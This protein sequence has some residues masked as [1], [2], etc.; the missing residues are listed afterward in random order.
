MYCAL[1]KKVNISKNE[2]LIKISTNKET[3]Y[4]AIGGTNGFVQV[5]DLDVS[6]DQKNAKGG[7]L[8][9]SQSLKYHNDDISLITWN[10]NY[11]K[12]TTCDKSGVIIVWKNVDNKWETEM[13]NNR[14]QSYVT[15][16]K[17]NRQ[18]QYLCFIYED[19]HAIVGTV[20]GNRSWG[21]DI[22]NSLYLIEWSPDGNLILLASRNQNI[23]ILSSSGQQLGEV[24]IEEELKNIDIAS[25]VWWSKYIDENKII[26]LKKHLM[27]AFINGDICL[28]DDENDIS[29]VKIKTN[30]KKITKADWNI[31]GDCFA[32]CGFLNEGDSKGCVCFYNSNGE[33]IKNIKIN[34]PIICFSFNAKGTQIAL[35]TQNTIYFG[36]IK[37]DYKWCYFGETLVYAFLSD[38]EHHTVS[39]WNTKNNSFNYKYVKN[40]LGIVSCSPFCLITAKI[41]KKGNYLL[42]LSNSIGS[43]VDNKIINIEPNLIGINS[44]HVVVSDGHYIYLWQFRGTEETANHKDKNDDKT[45]IINGEE[46]SINLLTHKMMKELCFFVEDKPNVKDIYNCNNFKC[47]RKTNDPICCLS[48]TDNY[49]FIVCKSGRGLKYDLLSLSNSEK[50]NLDNRLIKIGMSPTGRFLWTINELNYLNIWDIAKNKKLE[51]EKK[52]IWSLVWSGNNNLDLNNSEEKLN[53]AY[54]EKNKINIIKD[55]KP[56]EILDSNGYLAEFND[57]N[58]I[59][60]KLDDLLYKPNEEKKEVDDIVIKIETRALRDLRSMLTNNSPIDEIYKYVDENSSHKL[61]EIF[62]KHC[63]QNL[64][65]INAEKAMLKINDYMGLEFIKRIKSID[66]D[67]LKKAE[68]YQFYEDFDQAENEYGNNDR[69][70]LAIGMRFKLGQW[71]KVIELTTDSGVVQEDNMKM[72]YDNYAQQFLEE[73]NYEKAEEYFKKAGDV[74]G[75]INVWFK[76]E[77]YDKAIIYIERLPEGNELLLFL[78]NKFEKYGLCD[79]AVKCY[80]RYGD[81][82]KAIDTCVLMN[83]WN[84]AVEL[85]ENNNFFQIEGLVN[86][87]GSLLLEKGKKM[88]LVELYRKAHRHTDAAKILMKIAEDLKGLN[89]SPLTLKK[90][91]TIA[92]LEMESFKSRLIDA[93]ITNITQQTSVKNTTTLDTLITSDLSNVNDKQLNNPWK[94]AEAY[95]FYML[96]QSQLYQNRYKEALKTALRLVLYEKELGSKQVYQLIAL[97]SFLNQNYKDCSKALS[98]LEQ[99]PSL[100]KSQRQN[101][102]DLAVNI[103]TKYEPKNHNEKNIICP[104]KNCG[105]EISEYAI[106]CKVCGSNFSPCVVSGQSIFNKGYFKCKRCKHR[107]L[108][109]EVLKKGIKNCPLCHLPLDLTRAMNDRDILDG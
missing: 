64:D 62:G 53:F 39:F 65:F 68:V 82:K 43:P 94:G 89:A 4:I 42:I 104:S 32:I 22:R 107:S 101:F 7:Q 34:E 23:T 26:T 3:N 63:L 46:I 74:E 75:L 106:S 31:N 77:E 92:A 109:K 99:L 61:W 18:G 58:I 90:I 44:T 41:D 30:L 6:S 49:L 108:E 70:D 2:K 91:Y 14:E 81:I 57:M 80:L 19:G 8:S 35:E 20:D 40:M 13:I 5:V 9:F 56:E 48:M 93:Q 72:S 17:W 97:T 67:N 28:Y 27:L 11:D 12:L 33:F 96:C 29:P 100:T 15:D 45:I 87:F 37:Q 47:S 36:I 51:F 25:M 1:I 102:K 105:A 83:K 76:T 84:L 38:Q 95:H 86:K 78:G 73:K 10:D 103:F 54:M 52:D 79:E 55:L 16:L 69:K 88:D 21:N 59:S 98:T 24:E 50:Y 71:D 60:I 85:A 66:D